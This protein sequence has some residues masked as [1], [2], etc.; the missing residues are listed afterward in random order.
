MTR[1]IYAPRNLRLYQVQPVVKLNTASYQKL[2]HR[3]YEHC[4]RTRS[5]SFWFVTNGLGSREQFFR[6]GFRP[7]NLSKYGRLLDCTNLYNFS[8]FAFGKMHSSGM[9]TV[10]CSG[11]PWGR[12]VC[13]G[14][15]CQTPPPVDRITDTCKSITLPQL[16]CG[17]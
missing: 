3:N 16:R 9:R 1:I 5:L 2:L 6:N 10:R 15:F 8:V 12:G 7:E 17:R 4:F 11:R 14:G 13:L